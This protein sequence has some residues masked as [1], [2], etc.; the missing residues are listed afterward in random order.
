MSI[1]RAIFQRNNSANIPENV[2]G[3]VFHSKIWLIGLVALELVWLFTIALT[4]AT[5]NVQKLIVLTFLSVFAGL[6]TY[7]LP[8]RTSEAVRKGKLWLLKDERR[9]LV[10]LILI[11]LIVGAIYAFNQR[12][13][14]DEE[15]S[16]LAA[17]IIAN[18][19]V[20]GIATSYRNIPWLRDQHPPL[21]LMIYGF[22][23]R[24]FG[25]DLVF[26]RLVSVIFLSGTL[27]STYF[28]GKELYNQESGLLAAFV[29]LSF[30]LVIRLSSAAMMDIQL[31]FFFS[32]AI[33]LIIKLSKR[34]SRRL[35]LLSGLVI[36]LGLLTKYI[37]VLIYPVLLILALLSPSVRKIKINLLGTIIVS[38][39]MLA[40]WFLY[41]SQIGILQ[42]QFQ[43]ILD[44]SGINH[45]IR[46]LGPV[47]EMDPIV[48]N[49]TVSEDYSEVVQ[50][51]ILLLSVESLVT[52]IPSSL[53]IY[54]L[55]L[56]FLSAFMVLRNHDRSGQILLVWITIVFTI[57]FLTLLDH[58]YLLM[59]FPAIAILIARLF[60]TYPRDTERF[61]I[62]ILLLWF[63][64]LYLFVD[65]HRE[66]LLF[67]P[68]P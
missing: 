13:W 1:L 40:I 65:W 3:W 27:I 7:F 60:H 15:S 35:T 30:P 43:R 58:R 21:I 22:I 56:F 29:F 49:P 61:L 44:Y 66:V 55:P 31:T 17:K 28:L 47:P 24:I 14:V 2:L 38:I 68:N 8:N 23:L 50:T 51:R 41:A 20:E 26:P 5:T 63:G 19:G 39:T 67:L 32:L 62:L 57:L 48:V 16:F 10:I 6:S 52:R 18:Q 4:R 46:D 25:E 12:V 11:A 64:S 33:L 34:P 42:G 54:H 37:M 45:L 53:G 9:L 36:G 59:T